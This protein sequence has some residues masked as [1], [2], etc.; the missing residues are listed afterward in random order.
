MPEARFR[1]GFSSLHW[2]WI[3]PVIFFLVAVLSIG[4]T[5]V[6]LKV[7]GGLP[8]TAVEDQA[9]EVVPEAVPSTIVVQNKGRGTASVSVPELRWP[10]LFN[11]GIVSETRGFNVDPESGALTSRGPGRIVL[12]ATMGDFSIGLLPE[13]TS[14][15]VRVVRFGGGERTQ[16][17]TL[18]GEI[19]SLPS[20]VVSYQRVATFLWRSVPA[21]LADPSVA[22]LQGSVGTL[23]I[24]AQGQ[25]EI[26]FGEIAPRATQLFL[27]A[28]LAFLMAL[29]LVVF[30]WLVARA[31]DP[32]GGRS[33]S[34]IS[35]QAIAG[36]ALLAAIANTLS[37]F[38]PTEWVAWLVLS[39]GIA[40]I[41]I[42]ALRKDRPSDTLPAFRQLVSFLAIALVPA[43]FLFWPVLNWGLEYAG[44]YNTDLFQYTHLASLL[45]E[46][47]MFSMRGMP[48]ALNSGLI[49]GGA[50]FEWKSIDSVFASCLSI[51]T[52]SSSL[53]GI[54]LSSISLY[55]IFAIGLFGLLPEST[56]RIR[57]FLLAL[58]V[59]LS[60]ALVLLFVENYQS[61]FYFAAF[62]PGLALAG[63]TV[64]GESSRKLPAPG[65]LCLL[66]GAIAGSA[67][68]AYPYFAAFALIAVAAV[69]FVLRRAIRP[70]LR[71]LVRIALATV[72]FLNVGAIT[73]LYL[74]ESKQYQDAL[75]AIANNVLLQPYS[76]VQFGFLAAG[77][78]PYSWRWPEVD[79]SPFMGKIG[80][81]I[82][83]LGSAAW[84]PG[85][86]EVVAVTV[87]LV[88]FVIAVDWRSAPKR[89]GFVASVLMLLAFSP[90]ILFFL[91]TGSSYSVL[92]LTWTAMVLVPMIIVTAGYRPRWQWAIVVALVPIALLWARTDLLDR[93][94]WMIARD[95]A[96][97]SLS[98]SSLQ[99]Q[100]NRVQEILED[101]PDSVAIIRGDQPIV[102][103]DR[104][105]VAYNHVRVMV[106]DLG[107]SCVSC[108][109]LELVAETLPETI[110]CSSAPEVVVSIGRSAGDAACGK[111]LVYSGPQIQVYRQDR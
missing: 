54:V 35:L 98:H 18:P 14:R 105:N 63:L 85:L 20:P 8:P 100:L 21:G 25:N 22:D 79:P 97:A 24:D 40:V 42:G 33:P 59:L 73:F 95:G 86:V 67:L 77:T 9:W 28:A 7:T 102:G 26:P 110:D 55:L 72:A 58:L 68:L 3:A 64:F 84:T 10:E 92:K 2:L 76:P 71:T 90:L 13:S 16:V 17:R 45:K 47:S 57:G 80:E 111:P 29:L 32:V 107:V 106:R 44:Q 70:A 66:A 34:R 74:N 103:S 56:S 11:K 23:R 6:T 83:T 51:V 62:L 109:E 37:Y 101:G 108:A 88:T 91:A 41:A 46:H 39:G 49:A 61:H 31:L 96:A 30:G 65:Y 94:N 19:A 69:P 78:T 12:K 52:F 75:D 27:E 36:V 1:R 53:D 104:D 89:V 60:P 50:G 48:E 82:W 99:P 38:L 43:V 81:G 4:L 15:A 93:A 87:A 5:P